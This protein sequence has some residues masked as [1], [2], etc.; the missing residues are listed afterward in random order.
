MVARFALLVVRGMP[1]RTEPAAALVFSASDSATRERRM[2]L[3]LGAALVVLAAVVLSTSATDYWYPRPDAARY[4][5][6]ARSLADGNG[7][8]LM[9]ETFRLRPPGFS[10]L[11]A[12]LVAWRGYDFHALHLLVGAFG[13]AAVGLFYVL[14]LPRVGSVVACASAACLLAN[15]QLRRL[16]TQVLSDVP[17]LALALLALVALRWSDRK[18]SLARDVA[19]GIAI[20]AASYV[21]SANL[22]L[23]PAFCLDRGCRVL[24]AGDGL[25]PTPLARA[26]RIAVPLAVAGLAYLPWALQPPAP[27]PGVLSPYLHSYGTV[28]FKSDPSDPS[29]PPVPP[30]VWLERIAKNVR[31]HAASIASG[32]T[33]R[34]LNPR[35]LVLASL[36]IAA[37]GLVLARRREA[38]EWLAVCTIALL[39]VY[40]EPALRLSLVAVVLVFGASVT[41]VRSLAARIAPPRAA[42]AVLALLLVLLA[43]R[44]ATATVLPGNAARRYE[45]L[46]AVTRELEERVPPGAPIAGDMGVIYATLLERPVVTLGPQ[47][48]RGKRQQAEDLL[49]EVR[50]YALVAKRSGPLTPLLRRL[51]EEGRPVTRH[52]AYVVVLLGEDG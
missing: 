34:V 2:A 27:A 36:G 1:D 51:A 21:R 48:R 32:A 29:S 10:A 26:G 35:R 22:L 50:P 13:V 30:R 12:P 17:G 40:P 7:Y 47:M 31:F 3:V 16:S 5:M 43:A 4:L 52:G 33:S 20:A 8:T 42:D 15:P 9:G 24:T 46:L 37:L 11:L 18:P 38:P 28:L 19:V 44:S 39:L 49:R 41:A 6:A 45:E 14:L 25:A 23:L